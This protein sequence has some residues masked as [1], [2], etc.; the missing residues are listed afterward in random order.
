MT[1]DKIWPNRGKSEYPMGMGLMGLKT[2]RLDYSTIWVELTDNFQRYVWA[3][4]V[5][6]A[7]RQKYLLIALLLP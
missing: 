5:H 2:S 7:T 6:S 1:I 3:H 4:R